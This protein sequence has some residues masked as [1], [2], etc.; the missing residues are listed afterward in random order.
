MKRG[1]VQRV[2]MTASQLV[3]MRETQG[4]RGGTMHA[5]TQSFTRNS[6]TSGSLV[7]A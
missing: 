4:D 5:H 7:N 2:W 1:L 3:W 6:A